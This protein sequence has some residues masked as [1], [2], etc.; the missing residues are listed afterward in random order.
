M[1]LRD[2]GSGYR[3]TE[4]R[5]NR[6]HRFVEGGS[7]R[8]FGFGLRKRRHAILQALE[9]ARQRGADYVGSGGEKLPELDIAR[10]KSG[11]R[12]GEPRFRRPRGTPL[13]WPRHSYERA[14]PGRRHHRIDDAE[15]ALAGEYEAGAGEPYEMRRSR[16]HKRQPECNVTMPPLIAW[17]ETRVKPAARNIAAKACGLGKRRI[18]STR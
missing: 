17:N 18:D 10:A 1:H 16:D 9:V 15:N 4:C 6:P 13:Q 2:R 7:D 8:R 11:Q 3:R 14:R 12:R 5:E